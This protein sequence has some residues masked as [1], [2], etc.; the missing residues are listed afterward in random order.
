MARDSADPPDAA[1]DDAEMEDAIEDEALIAMGRDAPGEA[2]AAPTVKTTATLSTLLGA[3]RLPERL[4][5][6]AQLTPMSFPPTGAEPSLHPPTTAALSTLHLR[7]LEALNNLLLTAAASLAGG[8][9]PA[10]AALVPAAGIWEITF[11]IISAAGEDAAALTARGQEMRLEIL[12]AALGCAWGVSKVAAD[13]LSPLAV[14]VQMLMDVL[15]ALRSDAARTRT[16]DT[17]AALAARPGVSVDEN[18]AIGQWILNL[19]PS[20]NDE[21]LVAVLN[22]V[23]DIYADEGRDYDRPVF[24]A[25]NFL[26]A[27]ASSVARV[28]TDVRKIDRRKQP[29]LRAR[30]EEAYENLT[31]FVKYRRSLRL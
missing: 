21:I 16:L 12:E 9:D 11:G 2:A 20:A 18:R 27:L 24:I 29:E 17:L 28:R 3:L 25:G 19:L 22:A 7:A 26:N 15:P 4:S 23:I 10:I 30:A 5:A 31:A 6:L 13:Q 14:Q 8:A 1:E